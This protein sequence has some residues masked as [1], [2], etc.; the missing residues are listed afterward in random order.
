MV[1]PS[2]RQGH[3][4]LKRFAFI[5]NCLW[6]LWHK[7]SPCRQAVNETHMLQVF[8]EPLFRL[9]IFGKIAGNCGFEFFMDFCPIAFA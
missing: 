1:V 7:N 6:R 5:L 4:S 3:L 2:N 9:E 8:R